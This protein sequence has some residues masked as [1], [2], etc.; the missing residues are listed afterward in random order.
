MRGTFV[1]REGSLVPK[2]LA[3]PLHPRGERAR[4]LP[5]PMLIRDH[6]DPVRSMADGKLYDS[7]SE[8]RRAYRQLGFEELGSDAP[9]TVAPPP[10]PD[11]SGDVIQA[12]CKVRDGYKPPPLE[13]ARVDEHG[14]DVLPGE[15]IG[16]A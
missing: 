16:D 8:M 6:Q 13:T 3:A 2:H 1:Y 9:T 4:D 15:A 12:Y 14:Y 11:P 10:E 5:C 7:K